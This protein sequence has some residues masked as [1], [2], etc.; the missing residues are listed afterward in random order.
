MNTRS[1]VSIING[2]LVLLAWMSCPNTTTGNPG[3]ASTSEAFQTLEV[4]QLQSGGLT[5]T[6]VVIDSETEAPL[7][8]ARLGFYD[9]ATGTP[10]LTDVFSEEDGTFEAFLGLDV[11]IEESE[12]TAT[13]YWVGSIYPNP[14]SSTDRITLEYT[15]PGN[16]PETPVVEIFD[17][18]GRRV[19]PASRMA[20][21]VYFYRIRFDNNKFTETRRFLLTRP[22]PVNISLQ[23]VM[24]D[25]IDGFEP[26]AKVDEVRPQT[27]ILDSETFEPGTEGILIVVEKFGW[28]RLEQVVST[29][30]LR[31]QLQFLLAPAAAPLA[32]FTIGTGDLEAGVPVVFDASQTVAP[33]GRTLSYTWDFGDGRRGGQPRIARIYPDGGTYTVTLTAA[34]DE[35]GLHSVSQQITI[36]DPASTDRTVSLTGLVRD[37]F[38]EPLPDAEVHLSGTDISALTGPDGIAELPDVPAFERALVII[39]RDGYAVQR[40]PLDL[41]PEEEE[42]VEDEGIYY[43]ETAL[44]VREESMLIEQVEFGVDAEG[45]AGA[46]VILGPDALV[47]RHGNTVTGDVILSLTPVDISRPEAR[48]AFPGGFEA[49]N[50]DG[51]EVLIVSYGAAEYV[52]EQNGELLQLAPGRTAIIEIPVFAGRHLDDTSVSE[53]DVIPM[54]SLHPETG[55]WIEEGTGVIVPSESSPTGFVQRGEVSHFSWWNCDVAPNAPLPRFR[56][57]LPGEDRIT[58]RICQVLAKG[59]L[60]Q[61]QFKNHPSR[62]SADLGLSDENGGDLCDTDPSSRPFG[63]PRNITIPVD[64]AELFLPPNYPLTIEAWAAGGLFRGSVDVCR[65]EGDDEPIDIILRPVDFEG[66]LLVRNEWR[67]G[68]LFITDQSLTYTFEAEAGELLFLDIRGTDLNDP[69]FTAQVVIHSPGGV[70]LPGT[71]VGSAD[72]IS[73]FE[74]PEAG[75]FT[76]RVDRIASEGTF[77]LRIS[78]A[79][80]PVFPDPFM[81]QSGRPDLGARD[82]I[83]FS[84]SDSVGLSVTASGTGS[85]VVRLAPASGGAMIRE[86][87]IN[88]PSFGACTSFSPISVQLPDD[89]LFYLIIESSETNPFANR[90]SYTAVYSPFVVE[91]VAIGDIIEGSIAFRHQIWYRFTAEEGMVIRAGFAGPL[92]NM[93][94]GG[95]HILSTNYQTIIMDGEDKIGARIP[96]DGIYYFR[97]T[98]GF[99]LGSYQGT[100]DYTASIS[101]LSE[102]TLEFED[103]RAV[104]EQETVPLPAAARL[105]RFSAE[106]AAGLVGT[107][108][109]TGEA[110]LPWPEFQLYRIGNGTFY[111]PQERIHSQSSDAA[112]VNGPR[113]AYHIVSHPADDYLL[114]V[115]GVNGTHGGFDLLF[116]RVNPASSFTI[117]ADMSCPNADTPALQAAMLS[118]TNGGNITVCEGT[119]AA[120]SSMLL[121]AQDATLT[122]TDRDAVIIT[123]DAAGASS[124]YLDN[125]G[126]TVENLTVLV[127]A[128]SGFNSH[129]AISSNYFRTDADNM[130]IRNVRVYT[131]AGGDPYGKGI[132]VGS[133][134]LMVEEV[135]ISDVTTG[136]EVTGSDGVTIRDNHIQAST[137]VVL[138]NVTDSEV[139]DNLIE[140]RIGG[141]RGIHLSGNS[142]SGTFIEDNI[143]HLSPGS[144]GTATAIHLLESGATD[145]GS[146]VRRNRLLFE[147]AGGTGAAE[148]G[149]YGLIGAGS[150]VLIEQNQIDMRATRGGTGVEIFPM[151]S[152]ASS[153]ITIRNNI[154]RHFVTGG[155]YLRNAHM[156]TE[157]VHVY[158]NTLV[159]SPW[160][161]T[162]IFTGIILQ[163]LATTSGAL[164]VT[165]VNNIIR[166]RSGRTNPD[167]GISLPADA[168]LDADFNLFYEV[169]PYFDGSSTTGGNDLVDADPLFVPAEALLLLQAGSPAIGAGAVT[170]DYPERPGEDYSGNARPAGASTIGAHEYLD[171]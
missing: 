23:Q 28:Q 34:T 147:A 161:S 132:H 115:H 27:T 55:R 139:R 67:E 20:T 13:E 29:S 26:V 157:P 102:E 43:F 168:T 119:Y 30:G 73:L 18:L 93:N 152:N 14:V 111:E 141:V 153:E 86:A 137:G 144:S 65:A 83:A 142:T 49:V 64:G 171:P 16:E 87:T 10:L 24:E 104:V 48:E 12:A 97:L 100:R 90:P 51:E 133:A 122:G 114:M 134:Q 75:T 120:N 126:I 53:G 167:R 42:E 41:S 5:V 166:G 36:Q 155:I 130:T 81:R 3:F 169:A 92:R 38:G 66:G 54:W 61:H 95:W 56:C 39:R 88:C 109:P 162:S 156:Y 74:A 37:A 118:L 165:V 128:R 4:E 103:M 60:P 101:I 57:P 127:S 77:E 25:R 112:I 31:E 22:G 148:L 45:P 11:S 160:S 70:S 96:S 17:V 72:G 7:L 89:D 62:I 106:A 140:A 110:P 33:E 59:R 123:T 84:A 50:P 68:G 94:V 146:I 138:D 121:H 8:R 99:N 32:S 150:Q 35:G 170:A 91:D 105:Y 6:G 108:T 117:S 76:A 2:I 124:L 158:N 149:V 15:T 63:A 129:A 116:D 135:E 159:A 47:D 163:G 125:S 136:V 82:V 131:S 113:L 19:H 46:R 44:L 151:Q 69:D 164:P 145:R 79:P 1:N 85:L 58:R 143:L 154:I 98:A 78:D 80:E 52:F 107:I 71:T 9:A 21:G 40:V